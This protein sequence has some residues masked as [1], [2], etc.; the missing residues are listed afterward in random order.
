[1]SV[2]TELVYTF[3]LKKGMTIDKDS[4][5]SLLDNDCTSRLKIKH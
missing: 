4:L 1:M 3:N 5:K 2:F